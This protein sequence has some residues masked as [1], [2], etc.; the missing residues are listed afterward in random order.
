MHEAQLYILIIDTLNTYHWQVTINHLSNH[1]GPVF[2][3]FQNIQH[4]CHV[5]AQAKIFGPLQAPEGRL[6]ARSGC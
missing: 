6:S 1:E 2:T 4:G 5:Q 3:A